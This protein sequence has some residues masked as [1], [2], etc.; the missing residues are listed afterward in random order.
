MCKLALRPSYTPEISYGARK[1]HNVPAI[2]V[3]I[4]DQAITGA[5]LREALDNESAIIVVGAT[6]QDQFDNADLCTLRPDVL[7]LRLVDLYGLEIL[8]SIR[9]GYCWLRT[10]VVVPQQADASF[11]YRAL[12]AGAQGVISY[13]LASK[14]LGDAV[15]AV[16]A[17]GTFISGEAST[18]LLNDYL[19][20]RNGANRTSP[21]QR[22]SQRERQVFDLVIEGKTSTQIAQQL[23]ISPKSVDTYRGRLMSK[24]GV[25]NVPGLLHFAQEN[26][27]TQG[28]IL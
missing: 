4:V 7:I 10:V 9:S 16:H 3:L 20:L 21:L 6:S 1:V 24:F 25:S 15:R 22:L 11:L 14:T 2:K 12:Q 8:H 17:G 18:V 23:A 26:G 27:L 5:A 28:P 19:G 13:R